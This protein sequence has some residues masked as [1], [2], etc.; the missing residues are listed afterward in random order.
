MLKSLIENQEVR[1][2][3]HQWG[4][5]ER[6]HWDQTSN[7]IH[8]DKSTLYQV[9]GKKVTV[10][11][12]IPINTDRPI[13]VEI[14]DNIRK[15]DKVLS[16]AETRL[17]REILQALSDPITRKA[18]IEEVLNYI[19]SYPTSLSSLDRARAITARMGRHFG[20]SEN[21]AQELTR[22]AERAIRSFTSYFQE[23]SRIYFVRLTQSSL[24]IGQE[25]DSTVQQN[26]RGRF[27]IR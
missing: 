12:R 1:I 18:F 4:G 3:A 27:R 13:S 8:I 22:D 19:Q 10:R 7:D 16:T 11:I 26:L 23:G 9:H 14:V 2:D 21:I 6:V 15:K 24:I 17:L 5:R 20:L 25:V